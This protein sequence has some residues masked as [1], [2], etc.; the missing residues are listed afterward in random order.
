MEKKGPV[1]LIV[2]FIAM[3]ASI[4]CEKDQPKDGA[5]RSLRLDVDP[6]TGKIELIV[7]DSKEVNVKCY[8]SKYNATSGAMI[9]E[10]SINRI[11]P[12]SGKSSMD[13]LLS[14]I[15]DF[16]YKNKGP[17]LYILLVEREGFIWC[18]S[19]YSGS[20]TKIQVSRSNIAFFLDLNKLVSVVKLNQELTVKELQ[21]KI[22]LGKYTVLQLS[23]DKTIFHLTFK[24]STLIESTLQQILLQTKLVKYVRSTVACPPNEKYNLPSTDLPLNSSLATKLEKYCEGN[25]YTGAYW[26]EEKLEKLGPQ[27][28]ENLIGSQKVM[29]LNYSAFDRKDAVQKFSETLESLSYL[30]PEEVKI[31]AKNVSFLLLDDKN[32]LKEKT[33]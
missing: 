6:S 25:F 20:S 21:D 19:T 17:I 23:N 33:G 2:T 9:I 8:Q 29:I 31:V 18:E 28:I 12:D 30:K 22:G 13:I 27:Q 5:T 4:Q 1:I 16:L 3:I 32:I 11:N 26:N 15:S 24:N 14:T 10:L 7:T